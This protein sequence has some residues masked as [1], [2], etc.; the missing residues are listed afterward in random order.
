MGGYGSGRWGSHTK[1]TTVEACRVLDS[2][3]WMR[4]GILADAVCRS[5]VCRWLD[6]ATGEEQ[7]SIGFCVDTTR[8]DNAHARI[9][10]KLT[11]TGEQVEY[12]L[13]LESTRPRRGG[14]RWWFR[15]PAV[16]N[17]KACGRRV[18]KLYLPPSSRYFACHH[19]HD[20]TYRSAQE[21]HDWVERHSKALGLE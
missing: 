3:R 21:S 2:A 10:D 9:W 14:L 18:G 6:A 17:G 11:R 12:R 8:K 5:G 7:S 20:L 4:D 13:A 16:V 19:C 1:K 15:C